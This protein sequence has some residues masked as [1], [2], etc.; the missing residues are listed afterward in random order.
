MQNSIVSTVNRNPLSV[1]VN[2]VKYYSLLYLEMY[3]KF[4]DKWGVLVRLNVCVF[5]LRNACTSFISLTS[6]IKQM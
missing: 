2:V 4:G 1:C 6:N 5:S 3:L